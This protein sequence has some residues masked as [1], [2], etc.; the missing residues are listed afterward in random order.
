[1]TFGTVNLLAGGV[2]DSTGKITY[3]CSA[4]PGARVLMCISVG[5]DPGT[6]LY[7][8]RRLA[9]GSSYMAF[10]IYTNASRTT[11][12]GSK[13]SGG[14]YPPV[15]IVLDFLSGEYYKSD[16]I[17][18]YGRVSATGQMGLPA[19]T[20]DTGSIGGWPIMISYKE[21]LPT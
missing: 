3:G 16:S 18:L 11:L 2:T 6:G 13:N 12:W 10:N 1:M 4:N 9:S 14:A 8:P 5:P 19:G 20:Y 15:P 21:I 17:T 7:T